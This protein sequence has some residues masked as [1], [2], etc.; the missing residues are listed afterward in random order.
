VVVDVFNYIW[1]RKAANPPNLIR[2]V[3]NGIEDEIR[4]RVSRD[5]T[6]FLLFDPLPLDDMGIAKTFTYT[7]F[8]KNLL[9]NYKK[10]RIGDPQVQ[11][12]AEIVKKYYLYRG[13]GIKLSYSEDYEA[14]DYVE[15]LMESL[16]GKEVALVTT[17]EDWA[18]FIDDTTILI[19]DRWDKPFTRYA[20]RQKFKFDPTPAANTLYKALYGDKAD[21]ITGTIFLKKVKFS[22][23]IKQICFEAIRQ[24]SQEKMTID[25]FIRRWKSFIYMDVIKKEEKDPIE[26]LYFNLEGANQKEPVV[27]T[28]F[29]NINV[30]RSSLGGKD[31]RDFLLWNEER[32][33][34]NSLI[35]RSIFGETFRKSFGKV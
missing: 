20:F 27:D 16:R 31:V 11:K 5:G 33:D 12:A 30:I 25:D 26:V 18:G 4:Q 35:H 7:G 17:D 21:N 22:S 6:L 8:R 15:P 29:T 9:S 2:N 10:D 3:I 13:E 14:D 19:N 24:V 28:L 34:V 1:R 23:P 32:R